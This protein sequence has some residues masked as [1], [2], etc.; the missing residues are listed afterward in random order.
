[1]YFSDR[2]FYLHY[3]TT[4]TV[5]NILFDNVSTETNFLDIEYAQG[6]TIKNIT[7][8]TINPALKPASIIAFKNVDTAEIIVTDFKTKNV[9]NIQSGIITVG[10]PVPYFEMVDSV[11]DTDRLVGFSKQID[12]KLVDKVKFQNLIFKGLHYVSTDGKPA[13]RSLHR[14]RRDPHLYREAAQEAERSC[15]VDHQGHRGHQL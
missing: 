13:S 14:P 5:E 3:S 4:L 2:L 15:R 11:F 8:D 10:T 12:L 1:M 7:L 9:A 6:V